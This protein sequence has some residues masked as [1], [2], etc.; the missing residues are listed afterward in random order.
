[1][2]TEPGQF[3]V[4]G[5]PDAGAPMEALLLSQ[6]VRETDPGGRILV[7]LEPLIQEG[8]FVD[9]R[10]VARYLWTKEQTTIDPAEAAYLGELP[11]HA[12]RFFWRDV[13]EAIAH[14]E[15]PAVPGSARP[16]TEQYDDDPWERL[17]IMVGTPKPR[18]SR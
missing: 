18:E 1:M 17:V 13:L 8:E 6:V 5:Q 11:Q 7:F 4:V 16:S 15:V 3:K 14:G 9:E 12:A 10:L 2:L